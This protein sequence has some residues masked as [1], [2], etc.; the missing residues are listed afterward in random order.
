MG[1]PEKK[2]KKYPAPYPI[3]NHTTVN[4]LKMDILQR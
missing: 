4:M 2:K 1:I 3:D